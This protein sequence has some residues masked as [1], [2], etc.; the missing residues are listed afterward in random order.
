MKIYIACAQSYT[1]G[2]K[3]LHQMAESVSQLGNDVYLVYYNRGQVSDSKK[4]LYDWCKCNV[5]RHI[6]DVHSNIMIAPETMTYTLKPF[7]NLKKVIFW[8]SL[9][10][11]FWTVPY[12]KTIEKIRL[13]SYPII[14]FPVAYIH[15]WK[16]NI[17]KKIIHK[18]QFKSLFHIYNCEYVRQYLVNKGVPELSMHYLCGPVEDDFCKQSKKEIIDL[19]E[20]IIAYNINQDKVVIKQLESVLTLIKGMRDD[21]QLIPIEN[22]THEEV[23]KTLV[24]A[25]VFLDLG[26][27]PGPER[28]PR[29]AVL[30]YTNL[31]IKNNGTA[32][33]QIDYPIHEKYK[34]KDIEERSIALK[35]ISMVDSYQDQIDDFSFLRQK[36]VNQR[37]QFISDINDIFSNETGKIIM[38]CSR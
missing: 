11:Y 27:F 33:N 23:C 30:A 5:V 28:I 20:N 14:A 16:T 17:H 18:S 3:T 38:Y 19:K 21:I 26:S 32:A 2:T 13:N 1:G 15:L 12:K 9:D 37:S 22:M 4:C 10:F 24:S 6:E 29:E 7:K 8:L 31:L 34:I 36:V 25:K 35:A